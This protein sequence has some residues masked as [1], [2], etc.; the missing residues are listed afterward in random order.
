MGT[1]AMEAAALCI[2][3]L[4]D[5]KLLTALPQRVAWFKHA[6]H[7]LFPEATVSGKSE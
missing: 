2:L 6:R 1:F 7:S 5:D 4:A 3:S